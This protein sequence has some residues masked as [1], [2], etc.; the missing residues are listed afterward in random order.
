MTKLQI[1]YRILGIAKHIIEPS[2]YHLLGIDRKNCTGE[3][4]KAALLA[5]KNELRQ[6]IPGPE[7]VPHIV[8]FEKKQL[9][10]AAAIL[11]DDIKRA[12]YDKTL[13][14]R[15]EEIKHETQQR[16]ELI[17]AVR[18]EIANAVNP[19]GTLNRKGRDALGEILKSMGVEANNI[20]MILD[21]IPYTL[22]ETGEFGEINA[23]FF[24]SSIELAAEN[25]K[26]DD[27]DKSNLHALAERLN[28]NKELADAAIEG[29]STNQNTDPD[30]SGA[31]HLIDLQLMEEDSGDLLNSEDEDQD[32]SGNAGKIKLVTDV[33]PDHDQILDF[34][35]DTDSQKEQ[36]IADDAAVAFKVK[37]KQT[38]VE[39][40]SNNTLIK[41]ILIT[42]AVLLA[43]LIIFALIKTKS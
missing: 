16:S 9:E 29:F 28:I 4:V 25:G 24:T 11:A 13:A 39:F 27:S 19:Q 20:S 26:L 14:T 12:A 18:I 5:R 21:R 35:E 10:P 8:E 38:H 37:N 32:D 22:F 31:S 7:F 33:L 40:A 36:N 15:W 43:A 2:Y 17:E 23:D 3:T 6:N 1:F 30:D 42:A 41:Y 34:L